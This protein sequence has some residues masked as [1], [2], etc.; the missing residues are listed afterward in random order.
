MM[1]E[2]HHIY[3]L[4]IDRASSFGEKEGPGLIREESEKGSADQ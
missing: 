3:I 1:E 2:S 4:P